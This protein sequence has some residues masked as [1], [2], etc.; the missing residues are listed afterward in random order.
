MHV[1]IGCSFAYECERA[2]ATTTCQTHRRDR[3]Y[4]L[5]SGKISDNWMNVEIAVSL[6]PSI[7]S[8]SNYGTTKEPFA[9]ARPQI[10]SILHFSLCIYRQSVQKLYC[11]PFPQDAHAGVIFFYRVEAD[12]LGCAPCLVV[13]RPQVPVY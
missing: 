2:D 6:Y 7:P 13:C 12:C 3:H 5:C 1:F 4:R 8:V 9:R 10:N 11:A